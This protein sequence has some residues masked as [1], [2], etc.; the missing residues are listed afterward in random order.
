MSEFLLRNLLLS[1]LFR[2]LD[3]AATTL[4]DSRYISDTIKVAVIPEKKG[5]FLK[6]TEYEV[7]F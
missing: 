6:H 5:T 4:N 3:N 7:G 1:T 2:H